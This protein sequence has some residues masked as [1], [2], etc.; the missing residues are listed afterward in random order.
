M[1]VEEAT[2]ELDPP[3]ACSCPVASARAAGRGRSSPAA[4]RASVAS[5]TGTR[6][7]ARRGLGVRA[8]RG[9]PGRRQLDRDGSRDAVPRH[10]PAPRAEGDRGPGRDDATRRRRRRARRRDACAGGVRGA[11]RSRAPPPPLRGEQPLPATACRGRSGRVGD[12][13]RGRLVEIVELPDHPWF[14]A[15][16]LPPRSSSRAQPG[17][18]RFSG[19]SWAQRSHGRGPAPAPRVAAG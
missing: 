13:Q 12:V 8:A 10:R 14:V 11:R 19:T 5:R 4:S 7:H 9:R 1:T 2:R 15:S 3:T 18:R 17:P 16:R 6:L